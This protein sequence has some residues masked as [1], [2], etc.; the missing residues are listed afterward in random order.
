MVRSRLDRDGGIAYLAESAGGGPL[1]EENLRSSAS[2]SQ[3]KTHGG[4]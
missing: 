4:T 2:S 1:E 3:Q